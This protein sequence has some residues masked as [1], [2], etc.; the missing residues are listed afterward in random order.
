LAAKVVDVLL[1]AL[2]ARRT[3]AGAYAAEHKGAFL[4]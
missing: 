3:S 1:K 4:G 2:D